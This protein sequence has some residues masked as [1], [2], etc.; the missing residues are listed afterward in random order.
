VKNG[1][2]DHIKEAIDQFPEEV[3]TYFKTPGGGET[4]I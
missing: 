3:N 1:A 2:E 4:P